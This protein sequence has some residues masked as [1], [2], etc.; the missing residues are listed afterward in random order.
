MKVRARVTQRVDAEIPAS[1][2]EALGISDGDEIEIVRPTRRLLG[3]RLRRVAGRAPGAPTDVGP[4][5]REKVVPDPRL[6][7]SLT[8]NLMADL[9]ALGDAPL[10]RSTAQ[11]MYDLRGYDSFD[12]VERGGGERN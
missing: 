8:V 4:F 2:A 10:G 5:E 7:V 9:A 6:V 3:T 1:V 11:V 12:E